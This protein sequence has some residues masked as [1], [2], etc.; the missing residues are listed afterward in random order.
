MK[1][2]KLIGCKILEREIASVIYNCRNMI[3]VTMIRQKLH[4]RPESL[5]DIIQDEIDKIDQNNDRHSNDTGTNDFDAILLGYGLCSNVVVGLH[6]E[7]YPLVI[8]KV[9]DCISLFMGSREAYAEY[10]KEHMGTFYYTP[11]FVELDC[12]DNENDWKR[13]YQRYLIRYKGN[14]R[15]ARRAIEI[16]KSFTSSYQGLTYIK[17]DELNF[18]EYETEVEKWAK[19]KDWKYE[20][21]QGNNSLLRKL[22]DGEW[23]EDEFLV[24]PPKCQAE[25][26]YDEEVLRVQKI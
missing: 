12:F 17:W 6:S 26:S 19:N 21:F 1:R 11:G 18:P 20:V 8:P 9:H 23:T 24:V 5:R 22:A 7:K 10:Y 14:E 13:R 16:E 3:D 4:E 15:K 25:P 2:Y